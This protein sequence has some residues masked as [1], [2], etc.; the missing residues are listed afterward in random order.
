M[1]TL[2]ELQAW[3]VGLPGSL[4]G[5]LGV[6]PSRPGLWLVGAFQLHQIKS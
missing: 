4:H 2:G 1:V 5:R 3:L 6:V